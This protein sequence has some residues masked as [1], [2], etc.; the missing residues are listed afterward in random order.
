MYPSSVSASVGTGE[1]T[2]DTA[3]DCDDCD[4]C[5]GDGWG[6]EE[7]ALARFSANRVG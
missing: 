2:V 6:A 7:D 3:L 1:A 5:D 4:N